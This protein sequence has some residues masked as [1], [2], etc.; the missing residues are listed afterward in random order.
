M[1]MKDGIF[2]AMMLITSGTF[3]SPT[4]F[5]E[6]KGLVGDAFGP[7]MRDTTQLSSRH[8][9]TGNKVVVGQPHHMDIVEFDLEWDPD[10][11]Q[12]VAIRDAYDAKTTKLKVVL[13]DDI[14]IVSNAPVPDP[15]ACY[16]K[17]EY[18]CTEFKPTGR[19]KGNVTKFKVKFEQ[20]V[21]CAVCVRVDP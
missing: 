14:A 19:D 11:E 10:D 17:G 8:N 4:A 1:G 5:A 6:V 12:S 16:Y 15:T 7:W 2:S 21:D 13:C 9:R 3:A 18:I 20:T